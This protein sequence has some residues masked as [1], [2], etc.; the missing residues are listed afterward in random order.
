[1]KYTISA[2]SLVFLLILSAASGVALSNLTSSSSGSSG[3]FSIDAD[4]TNGTNEYTLLEVDEGDNDEEEVVTERLHEFML[5]SKNAAG[6][7]TWDFGD[8]TTATGK[9]TSHAYAKSGHYIVTATSTSIEAIVQASLE[10]TVDMVGTVESDNMECVCAPTA[11]DTVINLIPSTGL[12]TI[13]GFVT[14]EHDGSSESCTLR[15][16]LQEC[17]V[18][19]MLERT[20]DGS[21]INQEVLFD[22]TFRSNEL[23]V[24]FDLVDLEFESGEGLQLRLET[25]QARDWHKPSTEWSMTAPV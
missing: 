8:G 18:R 9:T 7:V 15:N 16:P 24:A 10:L 14:V 25:D 13:E 21:V 17:H 6:V 12:V 11:K 20:L 19:V 2:A 3:T 23:S 1:M 5:E 4:G 22:D